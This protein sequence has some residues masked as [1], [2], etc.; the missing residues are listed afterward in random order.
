MVEDRQGGD[1]ALRIEQLAE[2]DVV[3][4]STDWSR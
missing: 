1:Q 2:V 3:P 4:L